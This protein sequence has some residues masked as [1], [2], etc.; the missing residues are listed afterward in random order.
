MS[1]A[2]GNCIGVPFQKG[3][4]TDWA[5]YWATRT[6]SNFVISI[7]GTTTAT[8]TWDDAA[9]AADGLKLYINDFLNQTIAFGVETALIIGLTP[10]TDYTFKLVAY[11]STN[12][13][14]SLIDTEKTL[15]LWYLAGGVAAANCKGAYQPIQAVNLAAS[16][17]NLANP[18]INDA[19]AGT[20]PGHDPA[21]G[22]IFNGTDQYLKTGIVP[23]NDQTWSI[24]VRYSEYTT[25][26]DSIAVIYEDATKQFGL[27]VADGGVGERIVGYNGLSGYKILTADIGVLCCS[28]NKMYWNGVEITAP[29]GTYPIGIGTGEITFDLWIGCTHYTSAINFF[30]G[31]IQALAIYDKV[32]SAAE[33]LAITTEMNILGETDRVLREN[34]VNQ[35]FGAMVCFNMSTFQDSAHEIATADMDVDTFAPTGMDI[36][37]W[38]DACVSAG[39]KY[40][41]LTVK[42]Q[43]GFCLWPT[44]YATPGH[45]PYSIAQTAWYAA[46]GSPDITE[47]F[48]NG[49]RE[50]GLKVGIYFTIQ[51]NTWEAQTGTDETTDAA[52]Y[53]AMIEAQLTEILTNYGTIDSL[54]FDSWGWSIGYEEIP[55]ATLYNFIKAIQPNCVIVENS[56]DHPT[57]TSQIE[58]YEVPVDTVIP[59]L[60]TRLSEEVNTIRDDSK[61]FCHTDLTNLAADYYDA[62]VIKAAVVQANSRNGVYLLGLTPDIDGKLPAALV[63]RL[64]EIGAL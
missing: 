53:I 38:L 43:D 45:D 28:G 10:N 17:I 19:F 49:C 22:W 2:L 62:A 64:E 37:Q 11:K 50:R 54:W 14:T 36:D 12:E 58:T 30:D 63:T 9:E 60:N 59:A 4:G 26:T 51:D 40:A 33:V 46:N 34:Y 44:A 15:E 61:W 39:M 41:M 29:Y 6:P 16:K 27:L 55:Y 7:T 24:I 25:G 8:A 47:L 5:S 20:N 57:L 52:G 21:L 48:V 3:G 18:G 1:L 13:S 23:K 32:L 56:Q 42:H 31:N 35:G